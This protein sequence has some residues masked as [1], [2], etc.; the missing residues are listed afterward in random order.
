[1]MNF[2]YI[3]IFAIFLTACGGVKPFKPHITQGVVITEEQVSYLQEG[4]HK[5]QVRQ[6]LG[7]EY[8]QD[9]FQPA[10]WE[11]VYSSTNKSLHP[12]AINHLTLRFDEEGYLEAWEVKANEK[13]KSVKLK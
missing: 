5:Q 12:E 1:M 4:L 11:Y 13:L 3:T 10:Q 9:P 8:A 7:P 2:I 6:I